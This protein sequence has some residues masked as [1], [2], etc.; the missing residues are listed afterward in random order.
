MDRELC[1]VGYVAT[2]GDQ[3]VAGLTARWHYGC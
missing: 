1:R 3:I 2:S